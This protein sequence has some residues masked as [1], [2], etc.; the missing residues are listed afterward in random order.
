MN[1]IQVGDERDGRWSGLIMVE[2]W[3]LCQM[4]KLGKLWFG[5]LGGLLTDVWDVWVG[6]R[7]KLG[8][9]NAPRRKADRSE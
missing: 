3:R 1:V 6:S 5:R 4:S 2:S 8:S 7:L 9:G